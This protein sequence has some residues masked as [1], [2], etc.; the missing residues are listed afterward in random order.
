MYILFL[1]FAM[2]FFSFAAKNSIHYDTCK[3]I[4]YRLPDPIKEQKIFS[5]KKY[6][7]TSDVKT[8]KDWWSLWMG[9]FDK[10]LRS[11]L[12]KETGRTPLIS[13]IGLRY[14]LM[15]VFVLG[16][17]YVFWKSRFH[18][19]FQKESGNSVFTDFSDLPKN[20]GE[21]NPDV[22]IEEAIREGHYRVAIRWSFLKVLQHLQRHQKIS[23]QV[24]KT[25]REYQQ[26]LQDV[27]LKEAFSKLI[28]VFEYVWYGETEPNQQ[29]YLNY[30]NEVE[31]FIQQIV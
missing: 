14:G 16:L 15:I 20:I 24:S 31:L 7:Y 8:G 29:F 25:N 3:Q 27:K 4:Q 18:K 12:G 5:D 26:A 21:V 17:L 9:R 11:F 13:Y 2:N 19:I 22:F 10:W 6:S 30:R 28:F 1:L 23:W